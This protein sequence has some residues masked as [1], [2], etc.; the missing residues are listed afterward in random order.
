MNFL[1][2]LLTAATLGLAQPAFAGGVPVIDATAIA[3]AKQEFA[4]E[5]AQMVKELE[6]AKRLYD[7]VNGLTHMADIAEALN[8]PQ[9]RELLGPEA[10]E[11]ASLLDVDIDNLGDLSSSANGYLNHTRVTSEDISAEDFYRQELDRIGARSARDA[12]IGDRIV[13]S[14][15]NRLAGLEQLRQEIGRAS[16]QK[17]IDALSARL[18]VETAMLQ[19]DTNRIQGL[20]MLQGAQAEVEEQRIREIRALNRQRQRDAAKEYYK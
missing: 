8:N 15:D 18:Q 4:Q 17:E 20:A 11:I 14:A 6:E 16:T 9:V 10:M 7:A 2:P 3:N 1:R 19:N 13:Q 12:A 5:I